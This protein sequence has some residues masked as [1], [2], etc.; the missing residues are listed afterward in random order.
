MNLTGRWKCNIVSH[1]HTHIQFNKDFNIKFS[2]PI[3]TQLLFFL[4][5][6]IFVTKNMR[7]VHLNF[8]LLLKLTDLTMTN[9]ICKFFQTSAVL[10]TW[11]YVSN[12]TKDG[13]HFVTKHLS[14]TFSSHKRDMQS[15][16]WHTFV[17][18]T[19]ITWHTGR[20][21]F[22]FLNLVF[23]LIRTVFK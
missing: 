10:L 16:L 7:N 5:K 17:T 4:C 15:W 18:W 8:H 3:Y 6:P 11:C 23:L 13:V 14:L 20:V 12:Q 19:P 21:F 2:N 1:S 22:I 9:E